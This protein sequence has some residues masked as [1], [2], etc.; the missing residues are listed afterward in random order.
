MG[1]IRGK[2]DGKVRAFL[3]IPYAAPPVG[4][5]RWRAPQPPAGWTGA[6][7]A[8]K[9]GNQCAQTRIRDQGVVGSEDC[10]FLNIYAPDTRDKALPVM[11]WIHGGT[12]VVGSGS[13]DRKSVV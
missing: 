12:F 4:D 2:L 3:G 5:L 1:E 8:T 7:D 9:P 10:L 11:M 6:L 13:Q